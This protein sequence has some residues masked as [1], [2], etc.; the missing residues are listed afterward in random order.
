MD[1]TVRSVELQ[2]MLHTDDLDREEQVG[3][4]GILWFLL[5]GGGALQPTVGSE[6]PVLPSS[7]PKRTLPVFTANLHLEHFLV[8]FL[9]LIG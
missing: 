9:I 3:L 4:L 7:G 6:S 1:V 5:G 8:T 2:L